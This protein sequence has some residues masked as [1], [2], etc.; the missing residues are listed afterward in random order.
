[1][2][3]VFVAS[4]VFSSIGLFLLCIVLSLQLGLG[5]WG[6]SRFSNFPLPKRKTD[7]PIIWTISCLMYLNLSNIIGSAIWHGPKWALVWDG[8]IYCDIDSRL[9]L[10]ASTGIMCGVTAIARNLCL[11]I[12]TNGPPV[13]F[14]TKKKRWIDLAICAIFPIIEVSLIYLIQS[15]RYAIS[16]NFGCTLVMYTAWPSLLINSIWLPVWSCVAAGYAGMSAYYC[17]RRKKDFS[18]ILMCTGSGLTTLQFL[19]LLLFNFIIIGTM[20][21]LSLYIVVIRLVNTPVGA[22]DFDLIHQHF[23]QILYYPYN[24]LLFIDRWMYGTFAY[25]AFIIFGLGSEARLAYMRILDILRIGWIFRLIGAQITKLLIIIIPKKIQARWESKKQRK[26]RNKIPAE[27]RGGF[28]GNNNN[29]NNDGNGNGNGKGDDS[30]ILNGY[31]SSSYVQTRPRNNSNDS[32]EYY[33]DGEFSAC[34][35]FDGDEEAYIGGGYDRRNMGGIVHHVG[36]NG[37]SVQHPNKNGGNNN[38]SNNSNNINGLNSTHSA[39]GSQTSVF[40][41]MSPTSNISFSKCMPESGEYDFKGCQM[42]VHVKS[43]AL[44]SPDSATTKFE[45]DNSGGEISPKYKTSVTSYKSKPNAP[46]NFN[47]GDLK[48]YN[49]YDYDDYDDTTSITEKGPKSPYFFKSGNLTN[50]NNYDSSKTIN[51]YINNNHSSATIHRNEQQQQQH[52]HHQYQSK[53]SVELT[54]LRNNNSN[55]LRQTRSA[56]TTTAGATE[57]QH[58]SS[59]RTVNNNYNVQEKGYNHSTVYYYGTGNEDNYNNHNN[60]TQAQD[61]EKKNNVTT[62]TT[63]TKVINESSSNESIKTSSEKKNE[64]KKENKEEKN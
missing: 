30:D 9:Q 43:T 61:D 10:L 40:K 32:A 35:E 23:S 5:Q 48:Y 42:G 50:S 58:Q 62:S 8:K 2:T 44:Y 37:A 55:S 21:P 34:F 41:Q 59:P 45:I 16:Q 38:N 14:Q 4:L 27:Y 49:E 24:S 63:A 22:Y 12:S 31:K 53:E 18:D 46:Y 15:W 51:E 25:I 7:I 26:H 47:E 6:A 11:I 1:M 56:T 64:K 60:N 13:Y 29:N 17:Y 54:E 19:R 3:E 36:T 57:Q 39:A 33:D 28:N 52:Q 20:L